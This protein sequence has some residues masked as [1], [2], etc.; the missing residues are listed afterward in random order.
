MQVEI[1]NYLL[2]ARVH[3]VKALARA[4]LF[5]M[6]AAKYSVM[7]NIKKHQA[8]TE[9]SPDSSKWSGRILHFDNRLGIDIEFREEITS[10]AFAETALTQDGHVVYCEELGYDLVCPRFRTLE[11]L[12][13]H[14][15]E[16]AEK[17]KTRNY[18]ITDGGFIH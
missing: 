7:A 16:L 3:D 10:D 8:V 15:L 5:D 18:V 14:I 2:Q 9:M 13:A 11:L 6:E 1:D 12:I 4:N 17:I